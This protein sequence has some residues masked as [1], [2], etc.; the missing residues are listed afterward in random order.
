MEELQ[1]RQDEEED[2]GDAELDVELY[3]A[4]S[5][6]RKN[7][8]ILKRTHQYYIEFLNSSIAVTKYFKLNTPPRFEP[9]ISNSGVGR[10]YHWPTLPGLDSHFYVFQKKINSLEFTLQGWTRIF[11]S[12][13]KS[14]HSNSHFRLQNQ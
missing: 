4:R 3:M 8:I 5:R 12:F 6:L 10:E 7:I 1:E 14:T 11:M 9:T 13:K 2:V